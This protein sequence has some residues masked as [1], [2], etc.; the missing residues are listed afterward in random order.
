[1]CPSASWSLII[2]PSFLTFLSHGLCP[3]GLVPERRLWFWITPAHLC[4]QGP[5]CPR[6]AAC[7]PLGPW[8]GCAP[9]LPG[10]LWSSGNRS[11]RRPGG[12]G[13][14]GSNRQPCG[15]ASSPDR[16]TVQVLAAAGTEG[17]L[18][19]SWLPQICPPQITSSQSLFSKQHL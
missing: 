1:M 2:C 13:L 12:L 11:R 18:A 4:P 16:S 14:R 17:H 8:P 9:G 3:Q 6:K 15:P 7:P 5:R 19:S 10:P